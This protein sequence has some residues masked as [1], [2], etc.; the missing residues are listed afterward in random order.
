MKTF[1]T[2]I[3]ISMLLGGSIAAHGDEGAPDYRR[4]RQGLRRSAAPSTF[5]IVELP[6]ARRQPPQ[7]RQ[8][9]SIWNG[10]LIGA[11]VGAAGG[12]LWAQNIC[13]GNDSECSAIATPVGVLAGAG[14]GT[15]V[16]AIVDLLHK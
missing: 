9:D 13:D 1:I 10:V 4:I 12:F 2:T 6:P 11:G 14:I 8:R 3:V 16:G 7:V 5:A 15:A